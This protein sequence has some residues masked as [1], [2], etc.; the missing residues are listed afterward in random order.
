M[1]S[2]VLFVS[3]PIIAIRIFYSSL[4]RLIQLQ[5][6]NVHYSCSNKFRNDCARHTVRMCHSLTLSVW[7]MNASYRTPCR[8]QIEK[9]FTLSPI[10]ILVGPRYRT[11]ISNIT[12]NQ[13][14]HCWMHCRK[15]FDQRRWY[16]YVSQMIIVIS[17]MG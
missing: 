14:Q 16:I 15:R 4:N 6:S 7:S 2:T 11:I 9:S 10:P 12:I 17:V 5:I 8:M 3:I 1:N 13:L